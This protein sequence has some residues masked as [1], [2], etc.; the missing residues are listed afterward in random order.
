[1]HYINDNRIKCQVKQEIFRKKTGDFTEKLLKF[2]CFFQAG[3]AGYAGCM[4]KNFTEFFV[5][6]F[7]KKSCG[8]D[9][10]YPVFLW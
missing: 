7:L 5:F 1:M 8:L 4:S 3:V 6:I 9:P 2:R 10:V